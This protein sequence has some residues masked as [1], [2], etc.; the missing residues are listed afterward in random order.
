MSRK[1]QDHVDFVEIE[2]NALMDF[3]F[4][5]LDELN[6]RGWS[7]KKL[8]EALGVSKARV[9]QMLSSEANPTLKLVA[10]ALSVLSLKSSYG[11]AQ[12]EAPHNHRPRFFNE[13]DIAV[14]SWFDSQIWHSSRTN[15]A[16]ND[17]MTELLLQAA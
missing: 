6:A 16:E 10:R 11:S 13:C 1:I 12:T 9:T 5:I 17:N 2:E 8:A 7:Q 14:Q 3:Q 15:R 4:A